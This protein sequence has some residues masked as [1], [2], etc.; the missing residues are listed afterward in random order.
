MTPTANADVMFTGTI[1][2]I[3]RAT[4]TAFDNGDEISVFAKR[5]SDK[6]GLYADNVKYVFNS[7]NQKFI[8]A[9]TGIV[10]SEESTSYYATYPYCNNASMNF[11]F[12]IQQ[13]QSTSNG[14][15]QSDLCT[16]VTGSTTSENV[17]LAFAHRLSKV[18][19]NL[20]GNSIPSD[21]AIQLKEVQTNVTV[22]LSKSNCTPIGN[23]SNVT[24]GR[25]GNNS[26]RAIVPSQ[27]IQ[28]ALITAGG[29]TNEVTLNKTLSAGKQSVF[30]I[31]VKDNGETYV[32]LTGNIDDWGNDDDDEP[33]NPLFE[34]P[35]IIWG[36]EVANVQTFMADNGYEILQPISQGSDSWYMV[37]NGK[38]K[39]LFIEYDFTTSSSGLSDVYVVF[40]S[41]NVS[42]DEMVSF[43]N[44]N[45][46]YSY[47]TFS[48]ENNIYLYSLA[49]D[50]NTIIATYMDSNNYVVVGY[51]DYSALNSGVKG[52]SIQNDVIVRKVQ[53]KYNAK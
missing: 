6:T 16:A 21:I 1:S 50:P 42:L 8:P 41:N 29:K 12:S 43:I 31:E 14:Y 30:T 15:T 39:E 36:G 52:N 17:N 5:A 38:H 44:A 10:L 46:R 34:E 11:T 33:S 32:V 19:I 53:T 49:S 24:M 9:S 18:V 23:K 4:D 37:Y 13:D 27:S 28:S 2:P 3:T 51:Y 40:D 45:A 26:M 48:E 22:D 20:T 35:Y 47:I 7:Q 25:N